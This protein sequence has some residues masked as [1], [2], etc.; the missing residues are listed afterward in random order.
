MPDVG[1]VMG[2]EKGAKGDAAKEAKKEKKKKKVAAEEAAASE[3]RG[4]RLRIVIGLRGK[5][6]RVYDLVATPEGGFKPDDPVLVPTFDHEMPEAVSDVAITPM[7][8]L[9]QV[10]LCPCAH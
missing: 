9:P 10:V 3:Q 2:D 1:S 6:L 5:H 8:I 4:L 7:V